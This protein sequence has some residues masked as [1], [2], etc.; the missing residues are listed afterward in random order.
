[1]KSLLS[2]SLLALALS[3]CSF[4]NIVTSSSISCPD[5]ATLVV[6]FPASDVIRLQYV[7]GDSVRSNN[8][9]VVLAPDK[10]VSFR[11]SQSG[12]WHKYSTDDLVA[13]VNAQNAAVVVRDAQTGD[14]I[15]QT[16][17]STPF[18]SERIAK[19]KVTYDD[20]S[21]HTE[22]TANGD[23]TV[24]DIISTDT[25]GFVTQYRVNFNFQDGEA[26]YGLGAHMEDY[27][28][29][30]G[31]TMYLTQ[32]N[33]K[34]MV[35][36]LNSTAGYGLLF[37]AG[38][39]MKFTD[40]DGNSYMELEAANEL[41]LYVMKGRQLGDVVANYRRL[42]GDC[43][44]MPRYMFGY[45]QSKERYVSQEDLVSTLRE[46]RNRRV[47][48][49]MIVQDWSYW[50]E[51]WGYMKM[52][53]K[54]YPNPKAM[55]DSVH[56]MN[57]KLMVSIW[58]NPQYCP[59]E[60]D[61]RERGFMLEQSVYDVFNPAARDYYWSYA[62][63][64]FFSKGFDA[65]WCD[66]SEP[67]DGDWKGMG[68]NY[69]W[70]NQEE[71][72]HHNMNTLSVSLGE[73]RSSL[74]SLYHSMGIY[75]N[76][77]KTSDNKRVVNL[78]R[79]SYAGQQRYATITWNGDTHASWKSFKQ[80]IPA[81]LNFMATGCPYW[82]VDIGSFF[83]RGNDLWHRWF[84]A[85]QFPG[86]CDDPAYREY[87][88]RMFQWG[89]F[90]PMMRSHGTDTPREIWRF[91]EPGT[92]YYDAIL[93]MINIRYQ[94]LPYNYSN[95]WRITNERYTMARLLAFDFAD[96]Q[97]VLDIKD[98]YMFGDALLVCPVTDPGVASRKVYLPKCEGWYDFWTGQRLDGGQEVEA[99]APIDCLPLYVRQG[100]IIPMGAEVQYSGEQVDKP[101]DIHIYPGKDASFTLYDDEGD[102]YNCEKGEYST[103]VI[104]WDDKNHTVTFGSRNGT[105]NGMSETRT[106]N[107][108]TPSGKATVTYTGQEIKQ[109][110]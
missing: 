66:C 69:G 101:V 85:G 36:V 68:E 80:Q 45:I 90:L 37:D 75:E 9:G 58:P 46:Y 55:A 72:W 54:Y 16:N 50:P 49:D 76:Q 86:G 84:Y 60:K 77:R 57:A 5:G 31:K 93:K 74:Y 22:H 78:T 10:T 3:G 81:G 89:T 96:D 44:M 32:H 53:P 43:P 107:V 40:A 106:F 65:W 52:D 14:I 47:P 79:S 26:L 99:N 13:E 51:G 56:A 82:S 17:S 105:Y 25:V 97:R 102:N 1:M 100:S 67:L 24:K 21:A 23:V 28:N 92:P 34:A 39:G 109:T 95:A 104:K 41:D 15:F 38:C 91:G 63:N 6:E 103:I 71:R 4:S 108:V 87:Y 19:V 110:I 11:A 88:T 20:A 33:L 64:E 27:M 70:D 83:T 2:T 61:F 7:N 94:L 35:P 8:T 18:E 30:R 98:E 59:Q 29:L 73:E 12:D 62:N 42:T 48:I